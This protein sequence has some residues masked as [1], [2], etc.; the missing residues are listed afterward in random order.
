MCAVYRHEALAAH[1]GPDGPL[2]ESSIAVRAFFLA[3]GL[4][5]PTARPDLSERA[6]L[7]TAPSQ[8]TVKSLSSPLHHHLDTALIEWLPS[9]VEMTSICERCTD[10]AQAHALTS[11]E[12]LGGVGLKDQQIRHLREL[13]TSSQSNQRN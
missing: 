2:L 11:E 6:C 13:L 9:L 10:F 12:V 8:A 4:A 1:T 7:L 3:T 5:K